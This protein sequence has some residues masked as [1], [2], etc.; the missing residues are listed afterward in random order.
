MFY[1]PNDYMI[2]KLWKEGNS[3][4][5]TGKRLRLSKDTVK[6]AL[7]RQG[8]DTSRLSFKTAIR[9]NDTSQPL[10]DPS[11]NPSQGKG[12]GKG[13]VGGKLVFVTLALIF[14]GYLIYVLI[15]S[16]QKRRRDRE[17]PE[18]KKTFGFGGRSVEELNESTGFDLPSED[19]PSEEI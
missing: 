3:L 19:L 8:F 4:R 16:L 9:E 11:Q 6:R 15:D 12:K 14:I 5:E 10:S 7:N 17:K 13:N 2:V 18:I 1:Y